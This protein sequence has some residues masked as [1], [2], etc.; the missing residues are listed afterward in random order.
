[1][2]WDLDS[3]GGLEHVELSSLSEPLGSPA[4]ISALFGLLWDL[5]SPGGA[6][7]H[8]TALPFSAPVESSRAP[9]YSDCF[10]I[11]PPLGA[12]T[13]RTALTFFRPWGSPAELPTIR[14]ALG[15]CLPWG[16][17]PLNCHHILRPWGIQQSSPPFGSL[18]DLASPGGLENVKLFSCFEALG[19]PAKLRLIRIALGPRLPW[20]LENVELSSLS[21]AWGSP[22]ELRTIRIALGPLPPRGAR[23]RRAAS[24]SEALGSPALRLFRIVVGPSSRAPLHSDRF[25]TSPPPG[26]RKRRTVFA[27]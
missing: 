26:A 16:S 25:G 11:S 3:P 13:R 22:A 1:M 4:E 19:S 15:P 27:F 12:R 24:L 17:N 9:P 20:G 2:L 23:K 7:K 18:W 8:R 6:R 14:F 10:G 21:E 5:A